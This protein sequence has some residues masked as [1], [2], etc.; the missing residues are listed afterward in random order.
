MAIT[1]L[2]GMTAQPDTPAQPITKFVDVDVIIDSGDAPLAAYQ[3]E[4]SG[5]VPSGRVELVGVEGI[6]ADGAF[7][8][9]PAYDPAA[10]QN[11]RVILADFS[12]LP[13][14]RLPHGNVRVARVHLMIQAPSEA[15]AGLVEYT[16]SLVA[17]GGA[18]GVHIKATASVEQGERR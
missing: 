17:A 18:D 4:F 10:L 3:V 13:A 1:T 5:A 6:G 8:E 12:E 11:S 14:P 15:A 7:T 2:V 9:P 16:A